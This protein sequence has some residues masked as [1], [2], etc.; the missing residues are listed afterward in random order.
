[1]SSMVN[2]AQKEVVR[3]EILEM[4]QQ[5]EPVGA[6]LQVLRAGLRKIG[7]DIG[8]QE[9]QQQVGYLEGKN[10]LGVERLKNARLGIDRTIVHITSAGTDVLEG[11][12]DAVGISCD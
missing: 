6:S 10:L 5:S 12:A 1:M 8:E 11:N 2:L 9:L 7:I 4:A 3:N